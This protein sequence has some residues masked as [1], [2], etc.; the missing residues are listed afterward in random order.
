MMRKRE[1]KNY[2][3]VPFRSVPTRC[4]VENYKKNSKKIKNIKKKPLFRHFKPKY[5][6][7]VEKERK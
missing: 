3:S 2:R 1:N 7:N 5:V 4:M 6:E